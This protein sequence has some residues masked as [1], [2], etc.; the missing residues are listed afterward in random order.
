MKCEKIKDL[1]LTDYVDGYL[2]TNVQ[3]QV[4]AHLK[5][6]T[7]CHEFA[8]S[9]QKQLIAPFSN[10]ETKEAPEAVWQNIKA[11]IEPEVERLSTFEVVIRFLGSLQSLRQAPFL[12][13]SVVLIIG[14]TFVILK[15]EKPS[16]QL[17]QQHT[18]IE[19]QV[20]SE[21]ISVEEESNA[22]SYLAYIADDYEEVYDIVED[23]Y[24]TALEE[25]FL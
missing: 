22:Q 13:A 1:I 5:T 25:Y 15:S 21:Q 10:L 23:G 9:V 11:T 16:L 20:V 14:L 24:G 12:L 6:C 18:R 7:T 8:Q 17:A 19:Q 3:E 2:D 4:E